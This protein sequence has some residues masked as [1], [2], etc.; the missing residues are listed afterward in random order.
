MAIRPLVEAD[1]PL[2]R[3]WMRDAPEAPAWSDDDLVR[4]VEAPAAGERRIRR[5][6]VAE[7]ES[8]SAIA[9]FVVA[10][11][12]SI[13]SAPAECE[14]EFVF[15][16]TQA[17]GQGTGHTLVRAVLEW[18]ADRGAEEIRLELRTS[19]IRALRLYQQCGFT[20]AGSRPGYYLDPPEDAV[21]MRC[22]IGHGYGDTPV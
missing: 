11:S 6:W 18:A 16:V 15:V 9:G 13:P 19:N 10:T 5:G 20:M 4:I 2:I 12:L 8:Q 17:R 1:L 22:R 7:E 21:L 3:S 14:L